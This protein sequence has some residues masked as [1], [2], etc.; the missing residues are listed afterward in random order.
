[1]AGSLMSVLLGLCRT[2]LLTR[3]MLLEDYGRYLIAINFFPFVSMFLGVSIK[4]LVFRFFPEYEIKGRQDKFRG[5]VFLGLLICLFFGLLLF[6]IAL[7]LSDWISTSVYSDPAIASLLVAA[8]LLA[9]L[10]PF[11]EFSA[12]VLRLNNKFAHVVIPNTAGIAFGF[13]LMAVHF[14]TSQ[15]YCLAAVV[16]AHVIGISLGF[17]ISVSSALYTTF[18]K[19]PS[20]EIFSALRS[21]KEDK[22]QLWGTLFQTNMLGYIKLV[23]E[24]GGFFLLGILGGSSETAIYGIARQLLRPFKILERNVAV[25]VTPEITRL[26]AAGNI[27]RLYRL[28]TKYAKVSFTVG[29]GFFVLSL[30]LVKPVILLVTKEHY[31]VS[32]PAFYILLFSIYLTFGSSPF[33][34]LALVLDKLKRRNLIVSIRFVYL[35]T[36]CALGLTAFSLALSHAMGVMTVRIFNDWPLYKRLR[37]LAQEA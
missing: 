28:I 16:R 14:Y 34:P 7:F 23:G 37:K 26:K 10:Q 11:E 30:L 20:C 27:K 18:K 25:T 36:A 15:T 13:L 3:N 17:L 29:T 5:I 33:F 35:G 8:S 4:D 32:L 31:L 12:A 6:C 2:A 21:L 19:F 22:K 9:F 1:M 24:E